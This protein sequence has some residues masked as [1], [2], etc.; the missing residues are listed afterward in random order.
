[1]ALQFHPDLIVIHNGG[2]ELPGKLKANPITSKT[3]WIEIRRTSMGRSSNGLGVGCRILEADE[4]A[5]LLS[6][7]HL[8]LR[9]RSAERER[10][11][12]AASNERLQHFACEVAHDFLN[13]ISAI[14]SLT[15]WIVQEY[16]AVLGTSG[17]EDL[18]LLQNSVLKMKNLV[19]A[20]LDSRIS[21]G[22]AS[23]HV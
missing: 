12:L 16:G 23:R 3:P 13:P 7:I 20:L 18:D 4:P 6:T 5:L 2:R 11:E 19:E 8:V 14:S 10:D 9:A 1:M 21:K 22:S 15:T 17:R